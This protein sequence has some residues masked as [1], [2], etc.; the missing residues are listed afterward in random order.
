MGIKNERIYNP[1]GDKI[2]SL[3]ESERYKE[4]ARTMS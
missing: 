3:T 2:I 1:K 4:E